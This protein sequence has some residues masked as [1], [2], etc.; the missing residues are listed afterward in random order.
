MRVMA[1]GSLPRLHTVGEI[2]LADCARLDDFGQT[3][4][5]ALARETDPADRP[6]EAD[7]GVRGKHGAPQALTFGGAA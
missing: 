6:H 7:R 1:G 5:D 3:A 2:G 4:D